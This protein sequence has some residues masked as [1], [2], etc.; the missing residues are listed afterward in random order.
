M[1]LKR[2]AFEVHSH[3]ANGDH[4]FGI[5]GIRVESDGSTVATDG[6]RLIQYIP[7]ETPSGDE[8]PKTEGCDPSGGM[9]PGVAPFTIPNDSAKEII[10]AAPKR[11]TLPILEYIALDGKQTNANGSACFAVNDLESVRVF[12]P[13]K[14]EGTFPNYQ[15]VI[16]E[17][18]K[19][20]ATVHL[21]AAFLESLC[22]TLKKMAGPGKRVGKNAID[23][24]VSFYG[25]GKPVRFDADL[26]SQ[27]SVV[28]VIMP[29]RA[30]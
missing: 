5:N 4:R 6:H 1:L 23:V 20:A 2:A 28:A 21:D 19:A 27:G 7:P 10:K 8:F 12:H 29:R 11:Q 16:P 15:K 17:A 13:Q 14:I 26:K 30:D 3:A 22:S 18:D 9:V 24:K 25:D